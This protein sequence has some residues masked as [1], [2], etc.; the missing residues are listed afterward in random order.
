M[1]Y[2][3]ASSAGCPGHFIGTCLPKSVTTSSGMV[4]GVKRVQIGPGATAFTR[5]AFGEHLR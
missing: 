1:T 3:V 5:M 4:E 2:A